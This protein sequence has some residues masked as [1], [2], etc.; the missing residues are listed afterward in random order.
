MSK[1][2]FFLTLALAALASVAFATPS[3]AGPMSIV[4]GFSFS[5]I[6]ATIT[7]VTITYTEAL[8]PPAITDLTIG[9]NNLGLT[10]SSVVA[11]GDQVTITFNPASGG[12]GN[13]TFETDSASP[14]GFVSI[15]IS[16]LVGTPV[17][18]SA[19]AVVS[20]VAIVPEP[21]SIALLGIGMTGFLACRRLFKRTARAS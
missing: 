14:I 16:G 11:S 1:R 17:I 7:D 9:V 12:A 18:S 8:T 13:F 3:H 10:P 19:S 20:S 6:P 5:E 4:T 2:S 21:T 15:V